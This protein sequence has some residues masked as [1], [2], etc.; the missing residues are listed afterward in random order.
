MNITSLAERYTSEADYAAKVRTAAHVL[1]AERYLLAD[2]VERVLATAME[3]Y[4]A[5]LS[6]GTNLC[7]PGS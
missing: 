1:V 5:A 6:V 7:A 4:R 2:D 3:R